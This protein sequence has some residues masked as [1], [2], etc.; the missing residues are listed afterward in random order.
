MDDYANK[1]IKITSNALKNYKPSFNA[2]KIGKRDFHTL[3]VN[4]LPSKD[5]LGFTPLTQDSYQNSFTTLDIETA[6][7]NNNQIPI[8]ISIYN[9]ELGGKIFLLNPKE[10][11]M[12]IAPNLL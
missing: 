3:D 6:E 5:K 12:D 9:I 11:D 10:L 1:T 8:A 4:L 2:N 7:Y